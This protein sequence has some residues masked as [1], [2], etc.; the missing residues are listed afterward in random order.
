MLA[1]ATGALAQ[2]TTGIGFTLVVVP[3]AALLLDAGDVLGTVA[4]L[5]LLVDLVVLWQGRRSFDARLAGPAV[6]SGH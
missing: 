2:A 4:R 5:G 3:A 6:S 1:V